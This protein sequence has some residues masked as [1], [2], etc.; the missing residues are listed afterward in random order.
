[1]SK[2]AKGRDMTKAVLASSKKRKGK[3]ALNKKRVI[4]NNEK[5]F[6]SLTDA[7]NKTGISINSISNNLKGLSKITKVGKWEIYQ[8]TN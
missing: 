6:E 8:K 4:L 3:P 2:V 5:I 1:M 7:S